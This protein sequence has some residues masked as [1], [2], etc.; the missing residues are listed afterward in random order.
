LLIN[1]YVINNYQTLLYKIESDSRSKQEN[2]ERT[3]DKKL[4][5]LLNNCETTRDEDRYYSTGC[6]GIPIYKP[7]FEEAK[8]FAIEGVTSNK[9]F[10][11][12]KPYK[13]LTEEEMKD[14][15]GWC[16][17]INKLKDLN[18]I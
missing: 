6:N 2:E 5:E 16:P 14:I 10:G 9:T 8:E 4:I 12:H 7:S 3:N 18:N 1:I 17:E 15:S 13:Y 11:L